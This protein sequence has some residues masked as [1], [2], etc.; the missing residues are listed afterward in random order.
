MF[1]RRT[2]IKAGVIGIGAAA[3]PSLALS[4]AANADTNKRFVFILQRGAADGLATLAPVSDA[5]WTALRRDQG[6][7]AMMIGQ[8]YAERED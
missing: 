3:A 4:G 6:E 8:L 2:I 5:R 7:A 1:N